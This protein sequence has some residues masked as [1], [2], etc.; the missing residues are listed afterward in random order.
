MGSRVGKS[1]QSFRWGL[2]SPGFSRIPH[3]TSHIKMS[4]KARLSV[5]M[6]LLYFT[7]GSWFVTLGTYLGQTLRFT[8]GQLVLAYGAT[9]IAALVSPF[10][11][12]IVVDRFCPTDK[13]LA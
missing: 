8:P 11:I 13:L 12:G 9:A 4:V 7:C 6:F 10:F 1:S 5:M 3:P 2:G